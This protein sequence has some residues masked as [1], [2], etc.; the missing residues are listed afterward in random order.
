MDTSI[1]AI[2]TISFMHDGLDAA[3]DTEEKS[4]NVPSYF[5]FNDQSEIRKEVCLTDNKNHCTM[6]RKQH[7]LH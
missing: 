7:L 3:H 5:F 2:F 4:A 6:I 1:S